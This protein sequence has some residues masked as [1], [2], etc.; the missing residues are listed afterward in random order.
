MQISFIQKWECQ[1]R[2]SLFYPVT[3]FHLLYRQGKA[4]KNPDAPETFENNSDFSK[5]MFNRW[6]RHYLIK[7]TERAFGH[8]PN[9]D[10][11]VWGCIW[12]V[13]GVAFVPYSIFMNNK[14]AIHKAW[15]K[16]GDLSMPE[17]WSLS[18][19]CTNTLNNRWSKL[20][21]PVFG[22]FLRNVH[23]YCQDQMRSI[24]PMVKT[25]HGCSFALLWLAFD[26]YRSNLQTFLVAIT[27]DHCT[28]HY[29]FNA[30]THDF[31]RGKKAC[32]VAMKKITY[33]T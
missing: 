24:A 7:L 2:L 23:K 13:N 25:D 30:I 32:N 3:L 33:E 27:D 8:P 21:W 11:F 9:T 31:I 12:S 5:N 10:L 20:S 18:H 17:G 1:N 29:I 19:R 22:S 28:S 16:S 6:Y 4:F 26:P 14:L 15:T